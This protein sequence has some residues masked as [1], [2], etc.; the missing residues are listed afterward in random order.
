MVALEQI[1]ASKAMTNFIY[2]IG[3]QLNLVMVGSGNI[4]AAINC[5]WVVKITSFCFCS[6]SATLWK[7]RSTSWGDRTSKTPWLISLG[8]SRPFQVGWWSPVYKCAQD[9]FCCFRIQERTLS[10]FFMSFFP[11]H[12]LMYF[13][14]LYGSR[15]YPY[16]PWRVTEIPKD[17]GVWNR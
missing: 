1:W 10:F 13:L 15:K 12:M 14:T 4:I 2:S 9:V 16:P 6:N 3:S 7:V 11:F 5:W 17:R 8:A